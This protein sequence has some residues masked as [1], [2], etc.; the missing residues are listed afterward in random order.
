MGNG[1][2]SKE[3]KS[4]LAIRWVT[5]LFTM[6]SAVVLFCQLNTLQDQTKAMNERLELDKKPYGFAKCMWA[7]DSVA[8]PPSIF[9]R[10][11]L[12]FD[13]ENSS[14]I[15]HLNHMF[16]N[17]GREKLVFLQAVAYRSSSPI[18]F[19]ESLKKEAINF[20]D[21][22]IRAEAE[23]ANRTVILPG[24]FRREEI[25]FYGVP[26]QDRYYFYVLYF[27]EDLVG[28]LYVLEHVD[29]FSIEMVDLDGQ[30]SGIYSSPN[31][32][33]MYYDLTKAD[34]EIFVKMLSE[35]KHSTDATK[36]IAKALE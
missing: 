34:R 16:S 24:D 33:D 3:G 12:I 15:I 27:Y 18:E 25:R 11:N 22:S 14:F 5:L 19:Y 9:L 32:K 8:F 1:T 20:G 7:V 2:R 36:K 4:N 10:T 23:F 17:Q 28:N 21:L 29:G 13:E 35:S 30:K 26:I 6:A 31:F